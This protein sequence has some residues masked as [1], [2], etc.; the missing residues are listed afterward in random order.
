[1]ISQMLNASNVGA[2]NTFWVL[3]VG[4]ASAGDPFIQYVVAG[5]GSWSEGIDNSDGDKFKI[6]NSSTPGGVA[7]SGLTITTGTVSN[8]GINKS[9]PTQPLDVTGRA[10][11]DVFCNSG[12][13]PTVAYGTGAGTGPI[14]GLLDGGSNFIR[15]SFTTGTTPT[16]NAIIAT[17]TVPDAFPS[18]CWPVT[19]GDANYIAF[20]DRFYVE[21]VNGSSFRI[22][23]RGTA[24]PAS[25]PFQMYIMVGGY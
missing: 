3:S 11:A 22:R 14:T 8:V 7:N 4:G 9:A 16:L 6:T 17:I 24:L 21:T 19:D 12:K 2:A 20:R 25:T 18:L 10:R 5:V 1:M 15:F 13:T 23:N